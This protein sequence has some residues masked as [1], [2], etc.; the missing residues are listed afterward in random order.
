MKSGQPLSLGIISLGCAKNLVDSEHM[1]TSLREQGIALA[2]S[3]EE[4]TVVLVNTCAFI[5]DAQEESV[6]AILDACALKKKGPCRAVIVAGCLPQRYRDDL[7]RSFPEVDAFIGLDEIERVGEIAKRAAGGERGIL[8][9]PPQSRRLFEP[10]ADRIL[11]TGGTYAY[12]KIAEGC[13]HRCAFCAIPLIRGRYRSR[14]LKAIVR[15]VESLLERGVREVNLISQ[16][17]TGYGLDCKTGGKIP[18][19]VRALGKIGGTFWI[20]LLYGYPARLTD[21]LL[22]AMAETPHVCRYLDIPV[23]HS[24]PDVLRAM[25]RSETVRAVRRLPTWARE[26]LPGVTL[27]TTCLVGHPGETGDCFRHLLDYVQEAKFDRLGSFAFS[28]EDGTTAKSLPGQVA[29]SVA[30][31]R[32]DM[33]MEVQQSVVRDHAAKLVGHRE[34]VLIEKRA[35]TKGVWIGRSARHAPD[36]DGE[37]HVSGLGAGEHAGTF[38]EVDYTAVD[39]YDMRAAKATSAGR[40]R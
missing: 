36:V 25:G 5:R 22:D 24:H 28:P 14:P 3:P 11:L 32:R 26:R 18:D 40:S 29:A 15:E 31:S 2:P 7:Q 8:E 19:L 1:M 6:D 33:L 12:V 35:A 13:N 20:R 39:G 10:A 30:R 16:D 4:A 34:T 27:R 17:T 37:I 9:V 21:A 23:Q 38:V